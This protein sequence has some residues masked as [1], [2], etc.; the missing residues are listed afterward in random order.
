[1]CK[2]LLTHW[3]KQALEWKPKDYGARKNF[4]VSTQ[5]GSTCWTTESWKMGVFFKHTAGVVN[6]QHIAL[7]AAPFISCLAVKGWRVCVLL[8]QNVAWSVMLIVGTPF[9]ISWTIISLWIA[10]K[11]WNSSNASLYKTN[12]YYVMNSEAG[13]MI[14]IHRKREQW[15]LYK[16]KHSPLS[17][18]LL[19]CHP[20]SESRQQHIYLWQCVDRT[21]RSRPSLD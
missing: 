20:T 5:G 4:L 21:L 14:L 10:L 13:A 15:S 18:C 12:N 2:W 3:H 11:Q 8:N 7:F 19:N 1:M 9:L 6:I 16:S 17:P